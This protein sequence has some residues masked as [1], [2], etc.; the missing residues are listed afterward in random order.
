M[1]WTF[2]LETIFFFSWQKKDYRTELRAILFHVLV[3][4]WSLNSNEITWRR[5]HL[6]TCLGPVIVLSIS[7]I[8]EYS[9]SI[10]GYVHRMWAY[11]GVACSPAYT[12]HRSEWMY[13]LCVEMWCRRRNEKITIFID[14]RSNMCERWLIDTLRYTCDSN[15][16]AT[17]HVRLWHRP[18]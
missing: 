12:E 13:T 8:D 2:G 15:A 3:G 7:K 16:Y 18:N 1:T 10:V 14:R 9:V 11:T 6:I 17:L 4:A 5:F